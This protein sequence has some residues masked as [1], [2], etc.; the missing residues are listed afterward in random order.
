MRTAT[1]QTE[2]FL[3]S[4][5]ISHEKSPLCFLLPLFFAATGCKEIEPLKLPA[6]SQI[7]RIEVTGGAIER[8]EIRREV[9]SRETIDKTIQFI[10]KNNRNWYEPWD[11]YPI[12]RA[13]AVFISE[14]G[15]EE[16]ILWFGKDWV[17]GTAGPINSAKAYLWR[18][19]NDKKTSLKICSVSS[20]N[21]PFNSDV[22]I[23]MLNIAIGL[24]LITYWISFYFPLPDTG[25]A[26]T[27]IAFAPLAVLGGSL[28]IWTIVLLKIPVTTKPIHN[29]F[30]PAILILGNALVVCTIVLHTYNSHFIN[31]GTT[32]E[33]I[34]S[35]SLPATIERLLRGVYP[36]A[37]V[38]VLFGVVANG[39]H[40]YKYRRAIDQC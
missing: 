27:G 25:I 18:L 7:K 39:Y 26:S 38:F 3:L 34:M 4:E 28:V 24:S 8:K 12:P 21:R 30:L 11:T 10:E 9:T 32:V 40:F 35:E 17:G 1:G 36:L 31:L 33:E 14:Q 13:S 37:K 23:L 20:N 19:D 16:I 29:K 5:S 22:R 6:A 15:T 2:L